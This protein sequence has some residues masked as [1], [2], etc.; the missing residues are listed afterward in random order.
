MDVPAADRLAVLALNRDAGDLGRLV[1]DGL[2]PSVPRCT[3]R[4]WRIERRAEQ[5]WIPVTVAALVPAPC[6]WRC[7]S[8]KPS[9]CSRGADPEGISNQRRP[10]PTSTLVLTYVLLR[11]AARR[12]LRRWRRQRGEG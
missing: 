1:S 9:G 6:S 4:R 5:V 3:V 11:H 8:S 12:T 2:G 10:V 7:R